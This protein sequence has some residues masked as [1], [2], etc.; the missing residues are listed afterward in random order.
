MGGE[1]F[2]NSEV[3]GFTEMIESKGVDGRLMPMVVHT[4]DNKVCDV[5]SLFFNWG[6][7]VFVC[8]NNF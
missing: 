2:L 3:T 7:I 4:K 6:K 5:F 8:M 1:I